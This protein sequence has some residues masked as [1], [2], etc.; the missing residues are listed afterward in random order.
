MNEK[1]QELI[2]KLKA[3]QAVAQECRTLASTADDGTDKGNEAVMRCQQF[4]DQLRSHVK[5]A[6]EF[7][8]RQKS[9]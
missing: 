2:E 6:T 9:A 5:G 7:L 8:G 1:L 4:V 3:A